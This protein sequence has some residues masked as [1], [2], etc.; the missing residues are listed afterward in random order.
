M[1]N[2]VILRSQFS[3][4]KQLQDPKTFSPTAVNSSLRSHKFS[5]SGYFESIRSLIWNYRIVSSMYLM[6][7]FS[8]NQ[9]HKNKQTKKNRTVCVSCIIVR[10]KTFLRHSELRN[11]CIKMHLKMHS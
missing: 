10:L 3:L 11:H 8:R 5:L 2:E 7:D 4:R 9:G 1:A 6:K